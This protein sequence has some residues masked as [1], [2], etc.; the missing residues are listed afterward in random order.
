MEKKIV[1]LTMSYNNDVFSEFEKMQKKTFGSINLPSIID[2]W[3]KGSFDKEEIINNNINLSIKEDNLETAYVETNKNPCIVKTIRAFEILE[4]R[5]IKYDYIYRNNASSYVDKNLL[6]NYIKDKPLNNF[7][8]GRLADYGDTRYR[9][10]LKTPFFVAG[11]GI[12]LSRDLVLF[13]INKKEELLNLKLGDD[14]GISTILGMAG[15]PT[16][17]IPRYDVVNKYQDCNL[18]PNDYLSYRF[19]CFMGIGGSISDRMIDIN[20]M[21]ILHKKKIGI[22]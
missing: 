6:I 15:V 13:L 9:D 5:H 1:L 8:A 14:V 4:E 11:T 22:I 16:N 17:N 21:E 18:I 19:K 7:F 20:N 2:F 3:Y 10:K 12:L